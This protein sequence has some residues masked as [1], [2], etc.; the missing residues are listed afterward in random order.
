ME[1]TKKE[2][3]NLKSFLK[4]TIVQTYKI[5]SGILIPRVGGWV[6][7]ERTKTGRI[8]LKI[9]LEYNH[10]PGKTDKNPE[11]VAF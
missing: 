5:S 9:F 11:I 8:K 6:G 2:E 3:L 7:V 4:I 1:R 10:F